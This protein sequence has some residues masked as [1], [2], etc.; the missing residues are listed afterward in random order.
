M[1]AVE[2]DEEEAEEIFDYKEEGSAFT[3]LSGLLKGLKF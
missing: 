1:K 3:G 2:A